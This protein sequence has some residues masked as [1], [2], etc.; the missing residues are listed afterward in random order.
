M[1]PLRQVG[2]ELGG[3]FLRQQNLGLFA[4][5]D[6]GAVEL[7]VQRLEFV[8]R[9]FGQLGRDG[10]VDVAGLVDGREIRLVVDHGEGQAELG[11]IGDDVF[12]RLQFRHVVAR[13][14]RHQVGQAFEVGR[15]AQRLVFLDGALHRAFAPVV[16][17]Q[18]QLPVAKHV[19]QALQI[20]QGRIGRG[21][22]AAA[23]VLEH[24]LLEVEIASGGGHELPQAGRTGAG[25]SLR[26][27]GGLD[28]RQQGQFRRHAA[29]FQFLHH[30]EDV[31][32]GARR[33]AGD[34]VGAGGVPVDV[35]GYQL[36]VDVGNRI[37]AADA[38]PDVGFAQRI[39]IVAEVFQQTVGLLQAVVEGGEFRRDL[40]GH[41]DQGRCGC[42]DWRV[43]ALNTGFVRL[44]E[45]G[46]KRQGQR[47]Q[48][49]RFKGVFVHS[50][51]L[52]SSE[53]HRTDP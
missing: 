33:G 21:Q 32:R 38:A 35:V 42:S 15:L 44:A 11:R 6:D 2:G 14:S 31:A 19:I 13:F 7:R 9:Q 34:V 39:G 30:V 48:D 23:V 25:E 12:H 28:K 26:V 52:L 8:G 50:V 51:P 5:D 17:G 10:D 46:R 27:E 3:V 37:A 20:R 40:G 49:G 16:G 53:K 18:R 43:I 45:G 1:A 22:H 24:G 4:A 29:L 41:R 36:V 47:R